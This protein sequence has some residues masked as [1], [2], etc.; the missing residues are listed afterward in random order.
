MSLLLCHAAM[1]R[2][3]FLHRREGRVVTLTPLY[4]VK[5]YSIIL[6]ALKRIVP[7]LCSYLEKS[8]YAL[9]ANILFTNFVLCT[10]HPPDTPTCPTL[11][12]P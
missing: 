10:P 2:A 4:T 6:R 9:P 8:Y 11:L 5:K 7:D 12:T 3:V 1:W